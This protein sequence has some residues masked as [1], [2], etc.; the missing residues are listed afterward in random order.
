MA[1]LCL[2]PVSCYPSAMTEKNAAAMILGRRG[3]IA[4]GK[5]PADVLSAIGRKGAKAK[6]R[7][8]KARTATRA[9]GAG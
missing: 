3:G 7:K 1:Y 2:R 6:A 5:L 4:R 8:A 9:Q